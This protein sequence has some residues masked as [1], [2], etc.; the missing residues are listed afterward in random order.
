MEGGVEHGSDVRHVGNEIRLTGDEGLDLR[1][2]GLVGSFFC[3]A[4]LRQ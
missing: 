1:K 4:F 2:D 3:P